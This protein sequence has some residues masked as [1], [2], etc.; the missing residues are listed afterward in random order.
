MQTA[1]GACIAVF[2][3]YYSYIAF[4]GFL[5]S[6]FQ[7]FKLFGRGIEN[8]CIKI[9]VNCLIGFLLDKLKVIGSKGSVEINC[10]AVA[11]HMESHVIISEMLM[12]KT[13]NYMLS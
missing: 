2:E 8:V 4:K 13:R 5:A 6:V 10:Y 12:Y 1:A 11:S 3:I 9:S 7:F